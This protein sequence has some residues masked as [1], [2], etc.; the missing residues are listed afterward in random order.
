MTQHLQNSDQSY[1]SQLIAEQNKS[2]TAQTVFQAN[3]KNLEN[4]RQLLDQHGPA[5]VMQTPI[6]DPLTA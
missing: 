1:L 4:S 3:L 5:A 2:Q 6:G